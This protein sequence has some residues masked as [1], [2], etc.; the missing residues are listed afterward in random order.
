MVQPQSQ[1]IVFPSKNHV[2]FRGTLSGHLKSWTLE[3][4]YLKPLAS[5]TI[6][7]LFCVIL[8]VC[9][10]EDTLRLYVWRLEVHLTR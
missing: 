4:T 5:K 3:A 7:A 1:G 9:F 8:L 6:Q 2:K 10:V